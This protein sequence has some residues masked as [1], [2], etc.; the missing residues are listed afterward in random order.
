MFDTNK[1]YVFQAKLL[2]DSLDNL[3]K[4]WGS[5]CNNRIVKISKGGYLGSITIQDVD[6]WI[7]ESWCRVLDNSKVEA[8]CKATGQK[9]PNS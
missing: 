3:D 6:Y 2:G 4:I 1:T 9:N 5:H 8:F 7:L